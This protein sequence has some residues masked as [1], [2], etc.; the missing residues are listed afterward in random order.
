MS[1]L[2]SCCINCSIEKRNL[3]REETG[4]D[5]HMVCEV[6]NAEKNKSNLIK[7]RRSNEFV[8]KNARVHLKNK[9]G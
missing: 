6:Y 8:A 3:I 5:C 7:Q 4:H 1:T 2:F 9:K